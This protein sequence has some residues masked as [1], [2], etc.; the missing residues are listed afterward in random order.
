MSPCNIC[1]RRSFGPGPFGRLAE[2]G[3]ASRCLACGSL[4]RH[5]VARKIIDAIRIPA[6]FAGYRLMRFS[7]DPI[8]DE[9]WFASSELSVYDGDNSLDLQAIDRPD[10]AYDVIICSHVLEH[11]GD[12]A[13]ALSEL[14]RIL[15]PQGF[16][17]L[18]VPRVLTGNVTE[19]WGF[20]DPAKNFHYRGYGRDFDARLV[21]TLPDIH[22]IAVALPD[23]VTGDIKRIHV[24]TKSDFWRERLLAG[25]S[26]ARA[27]GPGSGVLPGGHLASRSLDG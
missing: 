19:D 4:E 16:L 26:A 21:N 6:H 18:I 10:S 27:V 24:V 5:R 25:V 12:D 17:V 7:P 15:S 2:T 20:P 11:V 8:V 3:V 9:S 1:G 14:I 23:P 22:I 13:R